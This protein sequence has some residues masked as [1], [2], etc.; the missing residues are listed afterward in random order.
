MREKKETAREKKEGKD[1]KK[2]K[3]KR[4]EHIGLLLVKRHNEAMLKTY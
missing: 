1:G 2:K 3:R 4:A